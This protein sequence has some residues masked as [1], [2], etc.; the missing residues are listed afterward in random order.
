MPV[1]VLLQEVR[2]SRGFSQNDLARMIRMSPQNIQKIEQGDAKSLTFVTLGRLCK[3]LSC[4]PGDLLVYEDDPDRSD[5]YEG[6]TPSKEFTV[7]RDAVEGRPSQQRR[8][9]R[10]SIAIVLDLPESA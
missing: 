2:K 6:M 7:N 8:Q 3:A 10:S 4:Q 5:E 1:K 9:S